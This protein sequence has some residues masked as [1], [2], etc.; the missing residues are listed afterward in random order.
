MSQE[1]SK[2]NEELVGLGLQVRSEVDGYV[3]YRKPSD[4]M[5]IRLGKTN[6]IRVSGTIPNLDRMRQYIQG[7]IL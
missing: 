7:Y 1:L 5:E 4:V 3:L 6:P 2:L